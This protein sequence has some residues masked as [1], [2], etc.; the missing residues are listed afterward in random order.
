MQSP[1]KEAAPPS[2]S[3][4]N[5]TRKEEQEQEKDIMPKPSD[6]VKEEEVQKE[7]EN[8]K[9]EKREEEQEEKGEDEKDCSTDYSKSPSSNAYHSTISSFENENERRIPVDPVSLTEVYIYTCLK[10]RSCIASQHA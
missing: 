6:E 4:H 1:S 3:H 8:I 7:E 9:E 2:Q 10:M 5:V